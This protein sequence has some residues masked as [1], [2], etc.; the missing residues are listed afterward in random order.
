[1]SA[2]SRTALITGGTDGI[3]KATAKRLVADGW[4][5]VIVARDPARSEAT[6]RELHSDPRERII[7]VLIA[8]RVLRSR[9]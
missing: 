3:G 6:V 2:R 9:A 8:L 7:P 4:E 5:V 1:M